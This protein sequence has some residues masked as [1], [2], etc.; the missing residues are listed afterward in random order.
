M[1]K[2]KEKKKKLGLCFSEICRMQISRYIFSRAADDSLWGAYYFT[3]R[4]AMQVPEY[5]NLQDADVRN[6]NKHYKMENDCKKKK[7]L[8]MKKK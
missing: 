4:G 8:N 7:C 6:I 2:E 5:P 1:K 3:L